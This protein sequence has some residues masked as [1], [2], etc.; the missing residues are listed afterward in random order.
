MEL[1]KLDV[2]AVLKQKRKPSE[3][4]PWLSPLKS[5]TPKLLL[6]CKR[7][8]NYQKYPRNGQEWYDPRWINFTTDITEYSYNLENYGKIP[9]KHIW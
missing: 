5:N 3:I 6:P 4:I 9:G 8:K 1:V 2:T 7:S